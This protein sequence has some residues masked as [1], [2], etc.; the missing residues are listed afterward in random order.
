M[1][2]RRSS[3]A[4][5][6]SVLLG[7]CI[8]G[9]PPTIPVATRWNK[10][11][12]QYNL[13]PIYPMQED[14]QIGDVFLYLP[15]YGDA[16]GSQPSTWLNRLGSPNFVDTLNVLTASYCQRIRMEQEPVAAATTTTTSEESTVSQPAPSST[17]T[18]TTVQKN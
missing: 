8:G 14:I 18:E 16:K 10:A 17:T 13:V 15:P 6:L 4:L 9:D 11:I 3:M 7:G 1:I 2:G 12:Q 5:A